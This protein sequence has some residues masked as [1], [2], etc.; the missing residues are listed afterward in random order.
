MYTI[1]ESIEDLEVL[2]QELL[3]K[4]FLAVDTEFR[5]TNKDN[6]R[7]ALLQ[8]NDNEEIYLIDTLALPQ[9]KEHVSFLFSESV[10]KII[11]SCK[12]DL[13]AIF[14]WTNKEMVNVFDTQLANAFLEKDYAI[15]YQG[16]VESKLGILLEKK[17]TRSNWIRRPLTEAQ[18]KYAALDVEYLINIYLDQKTQL[19]KAKKMSWY[20]EDI[21]QL[22][23]LTFKSSDQQI[24][25]PRLISKREEDELLNKFN[26]IVKKVST[27]KEINSTLFFSKKAQR[28]FL[29]L[30]YSQGLECAFEK[31]TKWRLDLLKDHL[32]EL[33]ES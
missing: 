19:K 18:L 26:S 24:S 17:E 31:L 25:S 16:L 7:L 13:E 1:I 33:I 22:I 11:H 12:E 32:I 14:S 9:P 8:I 2:N 27:E 28:D 30:I 21:Q 10:T 6:M 29:R 4:P 5:R 23:N 3:L 20:D 15:S